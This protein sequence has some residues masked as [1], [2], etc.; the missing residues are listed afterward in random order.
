MARGSFARNPQPKDGTELS[1]KSCGALC[2]GASGDEVQQS[3]SKKGPVRGH[4]KVRKPAAPKAGKVATGSL[5]TPQ[6]PLHQ[7]SSCRAFLM[8][9]LLLL[10]LAGRNLGTAT[11][12]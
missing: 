10:A 1:L 7:P 8:G 5:G 6:S 12:P 11:H 9:P 4:C 3:G 2:G